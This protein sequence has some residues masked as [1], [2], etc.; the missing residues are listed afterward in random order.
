MA[1]PVLAL[2]MAR[3]NAAFKCPIYARQRKI[4]IFFIIINDLDVFSSPHQTRQ[5]LQVSHK[6]VRKLSVRDYQVAEALKERRRP[7]Y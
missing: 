1:V 2:T 4:H 7:F 5:K 6:M 3:L